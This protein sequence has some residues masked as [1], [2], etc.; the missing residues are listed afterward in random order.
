MQDAPTTE[1]SESMPD[2]PSP[3]HR[4]TMIRVLI[5]DDQ[6]LVRA[7][8]R[9]ILEAQGDFEVVGEAADGHEAVDLARRLS[10]DV[11]LMDIRMPRVDGIEATRRV[12][13]QDGAVCKVL[14]LTTFD[15]DEY[16][17]DA[18]K[19]GASG[20]LLKS[21]PPVELTRA[22]RLVHED[23]ALLAPEITRRLIEEYVKR[24]SPPP[25]VGFPELTEREIEVLRHLAMGMTNAEISEAL[26]I[27]QAT[28]KSHI[29]RI[30]AKLH[31]RDRAQAVIVAYERGLVS[32][33]G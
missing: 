8:L 10:P 3:D 4:A 21:V 12:L 19:A 30:F 23:Q 22:V 13:G 5:C 16:V 7:G 28:V 24:P 17:Y 15:T 6:A 32:P 27:S 1:D 20:F 29:N 14:I 18:L 31:L 25:E 33:G 2:S 11:V 26:Y 9:M